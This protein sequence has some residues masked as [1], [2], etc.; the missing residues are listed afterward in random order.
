MSKQSNMYDWINKTLNPLCGKCPHECLYCYIE[1]MR[2]FPVID[3]KYSGKI[4]L[5]DKFF[6]KNLSKDKTYFIGNMIDMFAESVN[7]G[8]ISKILRYLHQFD[9]EYLFQSKNPKKF[10]RFI[11]PGRSILGTTIE[12]NRDYNIS[13]APNVY[14]RA[15]YLSKQPSYLKTMVTIEPVYDFDLNDMIELIKVA[16]PNWVNIGADSKRNNLPE[17]TKKKVKLLISEIKHFTEVKQKRNLN[18]L[19]S[20]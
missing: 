16:N 18:R 13:K 4:R 8:Y 9:N 7:S 1:S 12:T 15:T 10:G 14:E 5:E 19:L 2:K 3:N 17:P 20:N 6:N 11:F